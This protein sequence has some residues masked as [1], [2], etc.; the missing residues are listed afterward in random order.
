MSTQREKRRAAGLC[1]R[2]GGERDDKTKRACGECRAR[3][4]RRRKEK[5]DAKTKKG[6][7]VSR[8]C[9]N[10]SDQGYLTCK[11]CRLLDKEIRHRRLSEG[12]CLYCKS[13]QV[14]GLNTCQKHR[15]GLNRGSKRWRD[16]KNEKGLCNRCGINPSGIGLM[17]E[18]CADYVNEYKRGWT[19][20]QRDAGRCISCNRSTRGYARCKMCRRKK[21]SADRRHKRKK[22]EAKMEMDTLS[23][24]IGHDDEKLSQ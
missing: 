24:L 13:K 21:N 11:S 2:C 1:D 10:K 9:E 16:D 14:E 17:C 4:A 5:R 19:K 8:R 6:L 23:S 12:F 15:E 22:R 7:C 3:D 20:K 18:P